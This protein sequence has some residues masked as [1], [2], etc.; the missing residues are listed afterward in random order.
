LKQAEKDGKLDDHGSTSRIRLRI[1]HFLHE[2]WFEVMIMILVTIELVMTFL[3]I[4]IEEG[5]VCLYGM[6]VDAESAHSISVPD[7][8]RLCEGPHGDRTKVLLETFEAVARLIVIV[9]T[10]EMSFKV[11]VGPKEFFKN[12]W[13]LLDLIIVLVNFVLA[14]FIQDIVEAHHTNLEEIW[15]VLLFLR[16]WRVAKFFKLVEEEKEIIGTKHEEHEHQLI[17]EAARSIFQKHGLPVPPELA[18]G[19]ESTKEH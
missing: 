8:F 15:E 4:A 11:F 17:L 2:E 6:H 16:L 12:P 3:E 19:A 18:E 13:H 5:Y 14:F 7:G 1:G 9:F 10:A